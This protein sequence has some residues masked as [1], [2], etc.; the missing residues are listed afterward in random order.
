MYPFFVQICRRLRFRLMI[1][2]T[3]KKTHMNNF[4]YT[5]YETYYLNVLK[6]LFENIVIN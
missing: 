4:S 3:F 2:V 6:Y 5:Y 1:M